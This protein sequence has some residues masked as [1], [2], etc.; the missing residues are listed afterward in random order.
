[1]FTRKPAATLQK[2]ADTVSNLQSI[3]QVSYPI[4]TN[5]PDSSIYT[6]P[7]TAGLFMV[8]ISLRYSMSSWVLL[9]DIYTSVETAIECRAMVSS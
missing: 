1:M 6:T 3:V 8:N 2:V 4:D 5:V 7:R 9:V